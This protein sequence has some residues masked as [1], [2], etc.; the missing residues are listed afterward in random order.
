MTM[1]QATPTATDIQQVVAS[2]PDC[3]RPLVQALV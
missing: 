1:R 3:L 2:D